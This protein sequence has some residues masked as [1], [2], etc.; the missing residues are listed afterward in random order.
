MGAPEVVHNNI[1]ASGMLFPAPGKHLAVGGADELSDGQVWLSRRFARLAPKHFNE[2]A[3]ISVAGLNPPPGFSEF[4]FNIMRNQDGLLDHVNNCQDPLIILMDLHDSRQV[5]VLLQFLGA[6]EESPPLIL[7]PH[8]SDPA[9]QQ[10]KR[11]SATDCSTVVQALLDGGVHDMVVGEPE[12]FKLACA[13]QARL[14]CQ[15]KRMQSLS[16]AHYNSS[17]QEYLAEESSLRRTHQLKECIEVMLWEYLRVRLGSGLP[18]VDYNICHGEPH[19]IDNFECGTV[20]GKGSYGKVFMIKPNENDPTAPAQVIKSVSKAEGSIH[21]LKALKNEFTTM[22]ILTEKWPHPNVTKLYD[23]YHS[24]THL[25]FRMECGGPENLSHR[26]KSRDGK[27]DDFR[28][29]SAQKATSV[30]KQCAAV[31][32]HLHLGPCIAHRDIK[33][34]NI[35]FSES[36]NNVMIKLSDFG[37]AICASQKSKCRNA[38]GTLPFMAPEV[39]L[40]DVHDVFA[41]DV[42]SMGVVFLELTCFVGFV[43]QVLFKAKES[44]GQDRSKSEE[45]KQLMT[46]VSSR[47][48]VQGCV[49]RLLDEHLRHELQS[50]S[51]SSSVLLNGMLKL[52]PSDRFGAKDVVDWCPGHVMNEWFLNWPL[53]QQG[54]PLAAPSA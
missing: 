28:P 15:H 30:M 22:Q 39:I 42:W 10:T 17:N 51:A 36:A 38:Q 48:N 45:R 4:W 29:M 33:P 11:R 34:G 26:L 12:G 54:L 23:V 53:L 1:K 52:S 2:I 5:D 16:E 18:A 44:S 43:Q 9:L 19:Q 49:K 3:F 21:L 25:F 50:L 37:L 8:S 14:S 32:E 13:V 27:G 31:L 35:I 20:L 6:L 24:K 47:F 7:M 41:A 40:E 46:A